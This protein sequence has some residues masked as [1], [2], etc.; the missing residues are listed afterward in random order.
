MNDYS[1][2]AQLSGP[3][4]L[5]GWEDSQQECPHKRMLHL[6]I[7][8]PKEHMG[9]IPRNHKKGLM[10]RL[11]PYTLSPEP[12]TLVIYTPLHCHV[13]VCMFTPKTCRS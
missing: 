11:R 1:Y 13:F 10:Q 7:A 3:W 8:A 9:Q 5:Y 12:E 2:R 4:R 6:G